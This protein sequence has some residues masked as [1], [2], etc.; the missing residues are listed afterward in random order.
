MWRLLV[1][2]DSTQI[3]WISSE[4]EV[5]CRKHF[6]YAQFKQNAQQR[7]KGDLMEEVAEFLYSASVK[8]VAAK[9]RWQSTIDG[10]WTRTALTF[11]LWSRSMDFLNGKVWKLIVGSEDSL[12]WSLRVDKVPPVSVVIDSHQIWNTPCMCS[13]AKVHVCMAPMHVTL[14]TTYMP[15]S[16]DAMLAGV[17]WRQHTCQSVVMQRRQVCCGEANKF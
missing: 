3:S 9:T 1:L 7:G 14:C 11:P 2:A 6:R 17:S 13:A 12:P 15:V 4:L 10:I 16:G 5:R 8:R